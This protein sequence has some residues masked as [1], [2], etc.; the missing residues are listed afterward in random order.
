VDDEILT[1]EGNGHNGQGIPEK[2]LQSLDD[3]TFGRAFSQHDTTSAMK[4]Y[5]ELGDKNV[6][7]FVKLLLRAD[8]PDR[9]YVKACVRH[10]AKCVEFED[11]DAQEELVNLIAGFCS[12]KGKRMELFTDAVIGKRRNEERKSFGGSMRNLLGMKENDG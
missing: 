9:D 3:G 10:F 11:T 6:S 1:V 12:V 7:T 8:I 4:Y 2:L 5:V